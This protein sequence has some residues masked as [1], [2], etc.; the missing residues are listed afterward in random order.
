[1]R[2]AGTT[3]Y[4]TSHIVS[5]SCNRGNAFSML[6]LTDGDTQASPDCTKMSAHFAV[7]SR[8]GAVTKPTTKIFFATSTIRPSN[9]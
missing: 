1:M 8:N 2:F 9:R 4:L 7:P 3:S 5:A 6:S